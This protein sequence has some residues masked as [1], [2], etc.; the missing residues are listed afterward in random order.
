M[1]DD[2]VDD[3]VYLCIAIVTLVMGCVVLTGCANTPGNMT[4]EQLTASAK[5]KNSNI[6]CGN[7]SG[8]YGSGNTLYVNVDE[9]VRINAKVTASATKDGCV[10]TIDTTTPPK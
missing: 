6:A 7:V 5:D 1:N 2:T 8:I 4:P 9:V 10:T 3:L